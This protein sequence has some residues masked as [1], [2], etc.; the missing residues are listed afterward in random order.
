M[1]KLRWLLVPACFCLLTLILF[2]VVILL[3]YVPSASMEPTIKCGSFVIGLRQPWHGAIPQRGDVV[4]FLH[5]GRILIKRVVAVGG[6]RVW[7]GEQMLVVPE[8]HIYV[9]GDNPG[10]SVDSSS[11]NEP[12]VHVEDVVAWWI[13]IK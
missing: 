4:F 6:D 7:H 5:D 8:R 1:K 10:A 13:S 2:R 11:W 12:F 9:L 3:G